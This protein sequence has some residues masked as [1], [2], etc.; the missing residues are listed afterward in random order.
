MPVIILTYFNL[1]SILTP[2]AQ[3]LAILAGASDD[4]M[5]ICTT[6]A[7]VVLFVCVCVFV[8]PFFALFLASSVWFSFL[9]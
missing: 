2:R 7:L 3:V 5:S 9:Y 1:G 8:I 6:H 4:S